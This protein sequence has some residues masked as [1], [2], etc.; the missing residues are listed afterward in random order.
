M[1]YVQVLAVQGVFRMFFITRL[2][3]VT[4]VLRLRKIPIEVASPVLPVL[5]SSVREGFPVAMFVGRFTRFVQALVA[6]TTLPRSGY[7]RQ[8]GED[9]PNRVASSNCRTIHVTAVGRVV[10]NAVTR[11]EVR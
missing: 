2:V 7:P 11:F 6:L 9:L 1:A 5:G 3:G 10:I 8:V 4:E